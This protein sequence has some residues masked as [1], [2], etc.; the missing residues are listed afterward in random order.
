MNI[1]RKLLLAT[2]FTGIA[3]TPILEARG[4][5]LA[6]RGGA[7][8]GVRTGIGGRGDS[9][10]GFQ[11]NSYGPRYSGRSRVRDDFVQRP[12]SPSGESLYG[13]AFSPS[14][15]KVDLSS[16]NRNLQSRSELQQFLE[17]SDKSFDQTN[18]RVG[19]MLKNSQQG[20]DQGER[21][22]TL[23]K[24][25]GKAFDLRLADPTA[26]ASQ[27]NRKEIANNI[28]Q[29][30]NEHYPN[31]NNWFNERFWDNHHYHGYYDYHY[32]YNWWGFPTWV[33]VAAWLGWASGVYPI[34]Y[35]YGYGYPVRGYTTA[36]S[37]GAAP[38]FTYPEVSQQIDAS[39]G[40]AQSTPAA[41]WMPLGVF[42]LAREGAQAS[43]PS[44]YLQLALNK[45][46]V[47][48]GTY[49]NSSTD[50]TYPI[51]GLV[52][53]DTRQAAW[54]MADS[55]SSPIASAGIYNLTENESPVRIHFPD[56]SS[57][58]WLLVRLNEPS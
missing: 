3:A 55:S 6:A 9:R 13:P 2:L 11:V 8:G 7:G 33:G 31:R 46:G 18:K 40:T 17:D 50:K 25:G 48:A 1:A 21:M 49:Y 51:E 24:K 28:R 32:S 34:Y 54:K 15:G 57:Q 30:I 27:Q 14:K 20:P 42:A 52:N 58:D 36:Y 37:S 41:D 44:M 38:A 45:Q 35:G 43:T 47:I 23:Q 12:L 22:Q 10:G 4:G 56:G 29:N 16:G 5:G 53:K 39:V 19:K 26:K